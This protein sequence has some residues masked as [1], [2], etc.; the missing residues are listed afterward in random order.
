[1][2]AS[3]LARLYS[4]AFYA[5]RD[6]RTPLRYALVRIALAAVLAWLLAVQLPR[7]LGVEQRWGIA[8][9]TVAGGLAGWVELALLRR[10]LERQI[11]RTGVRGRYLATV[12]LAAAI[13]AG[14]GWGAK[15]LIPA[16]RPELRG[17]VVLGAFGLT[18]LAVTTGLRVPE[19][20]DLARR[21]TRLAGARRR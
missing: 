14:A 11:G 9:I 17:I 7:L 15:L 6:T 16:L 12:W 5:R 13:A 8:G 1:M 19:A 10:A 20:L 2:L 18:Y 3:T 21:V 4:S